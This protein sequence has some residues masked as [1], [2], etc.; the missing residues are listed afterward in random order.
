MITRNTSAYT[1]SSMQPALKEPVSPSIA[2]TT[3]VAPEPT[4]ESNTYPRPPSGSSITT[5]PLNLQFA[6][7]TTYTLETVT[8][9]QA[10]PLCVGGSGAVVSK[11]SEGEREQD[12]GKGNENAPLTGSPYALPI[13][14]VTFRDHDLHT[15]MQIPGPISMESTSSLW[16]VYRYRQP[17]LQMGR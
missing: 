4:A 1:P 7:P 17:Q 13:S 15:A 9:T 11:E 5:T 8:Y 10:I 2:T 3:T 16:R 12:Q 14:Y 6:I